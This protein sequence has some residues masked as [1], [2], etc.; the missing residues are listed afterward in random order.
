MWKS[1][2]VNETGLTMRDGLRCGER[3]VVGGP[4]TGVSMNSL[5]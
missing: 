5:K 1:G 3:R 2:F 4:L